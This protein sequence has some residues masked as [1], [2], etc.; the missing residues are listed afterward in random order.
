MWYLTPTDK[1]IQRTKPLTFTVKETQCLPKPNRISAL[2]GREHY[3]EAEGGGLKA[4]P[5]A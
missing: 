1:G 4:N 3:A 2:C 5:D